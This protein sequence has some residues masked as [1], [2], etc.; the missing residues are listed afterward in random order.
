MLGVVFGE[1][2][3]PDVSTI[4]AP[5]ADDIINHPLAVFSWRRQ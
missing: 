1:F 5:V 4:T 3:V 2:D